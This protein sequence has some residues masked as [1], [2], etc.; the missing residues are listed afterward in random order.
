MILDEL[1]KTT[2]KN[3]IDASRVCNLDEC[4]RFYTAQKRDPKNNLTE[5]KGK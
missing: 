4:S 3:K 5:M 2:G 1:V